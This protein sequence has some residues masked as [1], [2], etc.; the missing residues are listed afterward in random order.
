MPQIGAALGSGSVNALRRCWDV[1]RDKSSPPVGVRRGT[2]RTASRVLIAYLLVY[3]VVVAGAVVTVWRSG[4]IAHLDRAWTFL[5][6]AVAV[7]LG[8]ILALVTRK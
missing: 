7:I 2:G 6:I 8:A 4:L 5:T 1:T 3:Y